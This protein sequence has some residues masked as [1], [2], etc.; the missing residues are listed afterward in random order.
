MN[1]IALSALAN[2]IPNGNP[3]ATGGE[4]TTAPLELFADLLDSQLQGGS[5]QPDLSR[6][7]LTEAGKGKNGALRNI[8]DEKPA[9]EATTLSPTDMMAWLAAIPGM[10]TVNPENQP[11]S[12]MAAMVDTETE[13]AIDSIGGK[14]HG[15]RRGAQAFLQSGDALASRGDT[16]NSKLPGQLPG[17][18]TIPPVPL[19]A[20]EPTDGHQPAT[21][22]LPF[23]EKAAKI[24]VEVAQTPRFE[25]AGGNNLPQLV[26]SQPSTLPPTAHSEAITVRA[27]IHAEGWGGQFADKVVWI[28]RSDIQSAQ[29]NISPP[30]LGP[31]QITVNLS[32]D[33]ASIA[34]A[35][36]H[37]EVRQAIESA[38]PQL[39]EMLSST[40]INLGDANVGA[41]LARRNPE[42]HLQSANKAP[43][44]GENAILPASDNP[45]KIAGHTII[46]RGRG[47]V[48]LFA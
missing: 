34:F 39:K 36:P 40:G 48:D 11:K 23:S 20:G 17:Q 6:A 45:S 24:A 13:A 8:S 33:Q 3:A 46:Q 43:A 26:A 15:E 10:P 31:I 29:I 21:S 42:E 12:Q 2:L 47:M 35:S 44:G 28:A 22:T 30:Q 7:L 4:A 5:A 18:A 38:L 32:G 27:P 9:D 1:L 14:E 25:I 19:P 16:S 41:N 37:A